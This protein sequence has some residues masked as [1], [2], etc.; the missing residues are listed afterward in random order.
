M[1]DRWLDPPRP[2][3]DAHA[4]EPGEPPRCPVCGNLRRPDGVWFGEALPPLALAAAERAAATCDLMLV[5]G[6]SGVVYPAAGLAHLAR[7][8]GAAV[9]VLNTADSAL[10]DVA[11]LRLRAPA[12]L[13]LPRLLGT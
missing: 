4:P 12:A 6:T 8:R 13:I 1:R 3:C 11:H 9:V 7:R 10:D 2:C 5:V